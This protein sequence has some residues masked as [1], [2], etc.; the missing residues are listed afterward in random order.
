MSW[1]MVN[2]WRWPGRP[3]STTALPGTSPLAFM[4]T[5]VIVAQTEPRVIVYQRDPAGWR[6]EFLDGQ[7]EIGVPCLEAKLSL[8][9]IYA[10]EFA[11]E[12]KAET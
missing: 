9:Q 3:A 12:P 7:G 1:W 4:Q 11:Q 6:V 2:S 5:Y 8:E 10:V